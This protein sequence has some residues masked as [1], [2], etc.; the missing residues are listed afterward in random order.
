[1]AQVQGLLL[2]L[3]L[4]AIFYPV[5]TEIL[6]GMVLVSI[7]QVLFNYYLMFTAWRVHRSL[8]KQCA[9]LGKPPPAF[10][11]TPIWKR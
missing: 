9:M 10:I 5:D 11:F 2:S 1:M 3:F 4:F 6:G 7:G 8:C